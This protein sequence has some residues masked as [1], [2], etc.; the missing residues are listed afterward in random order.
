M[1]NLHRSLPTFII[2]R[3]C[4]TKEEFTQRAPSFI[5]GATIQGALNGI[6]VTL[7][8]GLAA[9]NKADLSSWRHPYDITET[10]FMLQGAPRGMAVN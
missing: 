7:I 4:R 9:P 5:Q 3:G 1:D 2:S 8:I 6:R 10:I